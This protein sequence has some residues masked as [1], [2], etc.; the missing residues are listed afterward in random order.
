[1]WGLPNVEVNGILSYQKLSNELGGLQLNYL[2]RLNSL[3]YRAFATLGV[4]NYAS[5]LTFD[6]KPMLVSTQSYQLPKLVRK[7]SEGFR[8]SNTYIF[9]G[10][11]ISRSLKFK[12]DYV[13]DCHDG[14]TCIANVNILWWIFHDVYKNSETIVGDIGSAGT[15]R[16]LVTWDVHQHEF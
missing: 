5:G 10:V 13:G 3:W 4:Y 7:S 8:G 9:D 6:C 1:V 12:Q 16:R 2:Y 14:C 11:V 15:G